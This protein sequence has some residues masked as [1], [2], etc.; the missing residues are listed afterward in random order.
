MFTGEYNHFYNQVPITVFKLNNEA[1][2]IF[3][4]IMSLQDAYNSLLSDA[5][6]GEDSF[7]DAYMVL[8]GV[9][10]EDEEFR[11]M[12]VN[13]ILMIDQDASAEY[14]TKNV[15][16]EQ[17]KNL[18]EIYD[19]QIYRISGCPNFT[20]E[21]FFASSGIALRFRL[22]Q[23]ENKAA[24]IV[25]QMKKA[26]QRR[27]EL[28]CEVLH[29]TDA[30]TVWRDVD[31]RF[32]RNIPDQLIPSTVQDLIEYKGLVS[33]ETLL[34]LVP[35]IDSPEEEMEKVRAQKEDNMELYRFDTKE[36][37]DEESAE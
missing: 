7:A 28:I 18:E 31:I 25:N 24:S 23:F 17:F 14:L 37:D 34:A 35:F 1:K 11:K 2:S 19:D 10:A 29:L 32:T 4:Q 36:D 6:D 15:N 8:K 9:I 20:D 33:D 30:D 16:N 13:K 26:L 5:Q 22:L 21:K 12:K 3:D 27:I